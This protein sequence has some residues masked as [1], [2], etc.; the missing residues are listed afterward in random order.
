[1][2]ASLMQSE[3]GSYFK[4]MAIVML[5]C[6]FLADLVFTMRYQSRTFDRE[7]KS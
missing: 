1:M 7:G 3:A 6:L 2:L 4:G 5:A